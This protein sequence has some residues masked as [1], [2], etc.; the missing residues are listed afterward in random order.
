MI[1]AHLTVLAPHFHI[2]AKSAQEHAS[3]RPEVL[4]EPDSGVRISR[5]IME[6]K[7]LN[8]NARRAA[9]LLKALANE[10][11]RRILC[12]L[13]DGERCVNELE[14]VVVLSQSALSQHL[15]RLRRDQ[16]VRTCRA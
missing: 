6:M 14:K 10:N 13:L 4:R 8:V 2:L 3:A 16:L 7:P 15:A 1:Q 12:E 5:P 9:A 11:R